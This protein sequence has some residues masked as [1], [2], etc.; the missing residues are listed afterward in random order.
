MTSSPKPRWAIPLAIIVS[1][2]IA[3]GI[4]G[5]A[6][7]VD[8]SRSPV[9]IVQRSD[10]SVTTTTAAPDTT[11]TVVPVTVPPDTTTTAPAAQAPVGDTQP[12]IPPS[13]PICTPDQ[14]AVA[15]DTPSGYAIIG[16]SW[17]CTVP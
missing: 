13:P 11:T 12:T 6:L 3:G 16:P 2:A 8:S 5:G 9:A 1:A 14:I 7:A 17:A 10:A 15:P 4:V